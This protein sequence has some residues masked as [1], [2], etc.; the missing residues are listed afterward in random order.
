MKVRLISPESLLARLLIYK[1]QSDLVLLTGPRGAGKTSRCLMLAGEA[2]ERRLS[3]GGLISSPILIN[4]YKVSLNLLDV[5]G[6]EQRP[7]A[8]HHKS[9]VQEHVA[10]EPPFLT[11]RDISIGA[12]RFNPDVLA[13]GNDILERLGN[14]D[15]F[16]LDE[17]GP[18]E[19]IHGQGFQ[20]GFRHLDAR[21]HRLSI[22]VVRPALVSKAIERWPWA[23]I[24][25][26]NSSREISR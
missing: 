26:L 13:W 14:C 8:Y 12:W 21:C 4:G 15:L 17:I 3:L 22:V 1:D 7:L 5:A 23:K 24:F 2:R 11:E 18:L 16:I 20:A 25:P 19:F 6:G 10:S 9:Y